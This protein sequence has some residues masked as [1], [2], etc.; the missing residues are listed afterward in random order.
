M[1][2]AIKRWYQ[3]EAKM[4]EGDAGER[5]VILPA[6]YTEYHWTARCARTLV[7]FYL[8]HWQWLWGTAV[9]LLAVYVG[10]LGVVSR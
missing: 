2:K 5:Y 7:E 9:A 10:Y 6:P 1:F 3:G 8:K 4:T